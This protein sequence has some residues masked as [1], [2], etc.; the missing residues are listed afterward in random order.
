M[1]AAEYDEAA[2]FLHD[3]ALVKRGDFY[4]VIDR[5]GEYLVPCAMDEIV[6]LDGELLRLE[7]QDKMAYFDLRTKKY[8]WQANGF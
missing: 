8:M 7:K 1:V 6:M 4:C 2:D 5:N 3:I